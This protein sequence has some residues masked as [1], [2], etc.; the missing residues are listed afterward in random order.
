MASKGIF[1]EIKAEVERR[2]SLKLYSAGFICGVALAADNDENVDGAVACGL[3]G[4]VA[5]VVFETVMP[6]TALFIKCLL[7]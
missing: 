3:A 5:A 7:F 6:K 1:E 2:Q 4:A